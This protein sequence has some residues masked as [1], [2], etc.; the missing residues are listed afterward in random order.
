[1]YNRHRYYDP[2]IGRY[3]TPDPVK[4]AGGLN[5]YQYTPNPTGWVDPLGLS[6]NCPPQNK[7]GCGAPDDATGVRVDEGET[8]LP[9]MAA[10]QRRARIDELSES[11]FYRRLK[12]MEESIDGAHFQQ[13]H[14]AQTTL[15]S[16]FDRVKEGRNPTTGEIERYE[17]GKKKGEPVI[18][19][20]ATRF[21]SHRDQFNAIQRA[22]LIFRQSGIDASRQP[23]D[24][25]KKIGEGF[26]REGLQYGEQTRA[27]VILDKNGKAKTSYTEFD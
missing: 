18:P 15:Q 7:P 11:V 24:M 10:E 19:S 21:L 26:K 13:K 22:Q 3:L 25:G 17:K 12:E 2:E 20:A 1:H 27:V 23:I 5:Q 8:P 9:K 4:L 16:Q 14:G 6:G